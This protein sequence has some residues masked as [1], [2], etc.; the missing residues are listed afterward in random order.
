MQELK[1]ITTA[2]I[3]AAK[4]V[5]GSLTLDVHSGFILPEDF[6]IEH[7]VWSGKDWNVVFSCEEKIA[8]DRVYVNYNYDSDEIDV[9]IEGPADEDEDAA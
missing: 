2:R 4:Y 9:A 1:Y 5:N 7:C 6:K 3:E 8:G